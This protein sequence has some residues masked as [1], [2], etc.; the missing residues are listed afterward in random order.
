M[1]CV[2][3]T[4]GSYVCT[5]VHMDTCMHVFMY[6]CMYARRYV[7]MYVCMY[8]CRC[9]HVHSTMKLLNILQYLPIADVMTII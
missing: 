3:F 8:V 4:S 1:C 2:S 5:Y 6:A 7:C 9:I